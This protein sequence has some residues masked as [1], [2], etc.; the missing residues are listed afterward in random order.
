MTGGHKKDAGCRRLRHSEKTMMERA[1]EQVGCG[2]EWLCRGR[3]QALLTL[4]HDIERCDTIG[5][6]QCREVKD[7]L[8]K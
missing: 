3:G 4:A 5:L 7:V 8:N 2:D 1:V 6:S